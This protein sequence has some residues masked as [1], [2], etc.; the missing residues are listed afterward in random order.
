MR[1]PYVFDMD[2][3]ERLAA[4][5]EQRVVVSLKRLRD[6]VEALREARADLHSLQG[7]RETMHQAIDERNAAIR[8]RD[9]A[10][11]EVARLVRLRDD[12][13][14]YW[15]EAEEKL[16]DVAERQREACAA[17]MRPLLRSMLSRKQAA[18]LCL[19]TPLVTEVGE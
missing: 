10:R 3:V 14:R 12:V 5:G 13:E 1:I 7:V 16:K 4:K 17:N 19:E 18:D 9:E 15:Q 6:T 11:A 8:E 2:Y